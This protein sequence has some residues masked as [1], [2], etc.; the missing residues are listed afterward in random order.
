MNR[1]P[2]VARMLAAGLGLAWAPQAVAAP[3]TVGNASIVG[4]ATAL[5][6]A[7]IVITHVAGTVLG[8]GRF[9]SG[10][11]GTVVVSAAGAGTTTGGVALVGGASTSAD[12]F[13]VSGDPGRSFAIVTASGSVS[14][15]A[16]S[17]NFTTAPSASIATLDVAGAGN[18]AVGGALTVPANAAPGTYTGTYSATVNYN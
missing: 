11:G 15:G 7:P 6:V 2:V 14:F 12:Q 8:F 3:P 17:M 18:F 1:L 4:E 5:I 16:L 10:S 9:T 13:N